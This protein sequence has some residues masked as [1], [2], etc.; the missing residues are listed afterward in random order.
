MFCLLVLEDFGPSNED[1]IAMCWYVSE[2]SSSVL[3]RNS[4]LGCELLYLMS[5]Y[6]CMYVCMFV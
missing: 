3:L 5:L 1:T 2:H 6:V 4:M